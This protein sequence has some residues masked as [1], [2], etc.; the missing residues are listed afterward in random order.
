M[1]EVALTICFVGMNAAMVGLA[2][3]T[4]RTAA[5]CHAITRDAIKHASDAWAHAGKYSERALTFAK[6]TENRHRELTE[7]IWEDMQ[8]MDAYVSGDVFG[9]PRKEEEPN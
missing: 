5:A 2:W 4:Y 8:S 1:S 3:I 6:D 7:Q 9:P